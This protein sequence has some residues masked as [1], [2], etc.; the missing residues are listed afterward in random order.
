[1]KV[2]DIFN[3]IPGNSFELIDMGKGENANINFVAR[4]STHNGVTGVVDE[5]PGCKPFPAGLLTVALSGNGVCSS[6]VQTKP[7]YT[8]Y[9]VMVLM[10]K[11]AMTFNEKMFYALCIKKNAYRYAWGRQANKTIKDI[12]LPDSIPDYVNTITVAPISTTIEYQPKCAL[13]TSLWKEHKLLDL[14]SIE[15]GGRLVKEN[16]I[17]GDIP[18]V[19]AGYQN[20]GIAEK[21]SSDENK[22]YCDKITIDMF[23]NA[24]YRSYPFYCDDNIIVLNSKMPLSKY[25]KIFLATII[26]ADA[27]RYSYGRQYRQKDCKNHIIKLPTNADGTPNFSYM[28]AYIKALPYGDRI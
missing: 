21:I 24:F 16:R 14:F 2:N 13:D 11:I 27:Y 12:D 5:V 26:Q 4:A 1:M 17:P 10:P 8:A 28:E 25:A 23:G 19:T 3:L 18:L 15:R 6:F 7:F 20:E 9:H 22:L